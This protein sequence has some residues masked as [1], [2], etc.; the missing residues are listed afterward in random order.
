MRVGNDDHEQQLTRQRGT[1]RNTTGTTRRKLLQRWMH[2]RYFVSLFDPFA[3]VRIE[4]NEHYRCVQEMMTTNDNQLGK[5]EQ[6][7]TQLEQ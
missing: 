1:P 2:V 4:L 3:L 6:R 7:A 5:A